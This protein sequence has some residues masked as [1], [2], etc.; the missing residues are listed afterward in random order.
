MHN[1]KT[2]VDNDN[3]RARVVIDE[4]NHHYLFDGQSLKNDGIGKGSGT[5]L[6]CDHQI[7]GS[8]H[9]IIYYFNVNPVLCA[10]KRTHRFKF[11]KHSL[12]NIWR[13]IDLYPAGFPS[14]SKNS[15]L[16]FFP[17]CDGTL[18]RVWSATLPDSPTTR[19]YSWEHVR[20]WARPV[21]CNC[22]QFFFDMSE[23]EVTWCKVWAR[24]R[25][26]QSLDSAGLNTFLRYPGI[27]KTCVLH[28]N[29][30]I[31]AKEGIVAWL[32]CWNINRTVT[33]VDGRQNRNQAFF[34]ISFPLDSF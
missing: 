27:V 32:A 3:Y 29:D 25:M 20:V 18:H 28:I 9:H 33:S 19:R 16:F 11:Y 15:L 6:N 8:K 4:T 30:K 26:R 24:G 21:L 13:F 7:N 23:E 5:S 22:R 31:I 1:P 34:Y 2:K 10:L 14:V 17:T 12:I